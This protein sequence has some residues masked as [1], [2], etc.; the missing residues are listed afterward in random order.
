MKDFLRNWTIAALAFGAV[1]VAYS[2]QTAWNLE[3][4]TMCI[5]QR[6]AF[7]VIGVGAV[8]PYVLSEGFRPLWPYTS[9]L[10][11]VIGVLASIR[12]QWAISVP[13][14]TCGRDKVAAA[15]NGAPWVDTWPAM[16]E[17]TGICGDKVA[18]VLGLPFHGWSALLFVL[19]G[20]LVW[21]R[22]RART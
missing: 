5:V 14:M 8:G 19:A 21:F 15:L 7:L 3:P 13:S 9:T 20:V 17:A 6:Y 10:A 2:L 16:F 4:C 1:A 18:P 11:S 12:I 22:R